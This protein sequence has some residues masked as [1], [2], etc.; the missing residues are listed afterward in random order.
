MKQP[1]MHHGQRAD[2][3]KVC[4]EP[5]TGVRREQRGEESII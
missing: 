4:G 5:A 1:L 2:P 3:A